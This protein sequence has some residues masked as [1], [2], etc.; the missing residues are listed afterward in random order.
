MKVKGKLIEIRRKEDNMVFTHSGTFHADEVFA[1]AILNIVIGVS[2]TVVRLPYV[3]GFAEFVYD[4]GEGAYDHHQKNKEYRKNG[5]PYAACGLVWRSFGCAALEALGCPEKYISKIFDRVE[6]EIIQGIDA[7]DN[8]FPMYDKGTKPAYSVL[9]VSRMIGDMNPTWE[10]RESATDTDA[11]FDS[12]FLEACSLAEKVLRCSIAKMIAAEKA[13]NIINGAIENASEGVIELP[14]AVDW[15][16]HICASEQAAECLYVVF[17]S[18]RGGYMVQAIPVTPGSSEDRKPLPSEWR[19]LRDEQLEE[20]TG[21]KYAMFV[22]TSGY[23]GGAYDRK[24][25]L[26]MAKKAVK[27]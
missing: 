24:S 9:G 27:M 10:K 4:I 17:P 8:G 1:T 14:V 20:V 23:I 18:S 21:I 6:T 11:L 2:L 12:C 3:P 7:V 15:Q 25:A 16:A 13:E 22:H 26:E 5:I 19:G